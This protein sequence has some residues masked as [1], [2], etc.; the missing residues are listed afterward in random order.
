[1]FFYFLSSKI[2]PLG[3]LC[4]SF[5]TSQIFGGMTNSFK[6]KPMGTYAL[7]P[8]NNVK[9][10]RVTLWVDTD[11]QTGL[12]NVLCYL[13]LKMSMSDVLEIYFQQTNE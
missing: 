6:Y 2:T 11:V 4:P 13:N 12:Q 7:T 9:R 10:E 8:K 5:V 1:M 3:I